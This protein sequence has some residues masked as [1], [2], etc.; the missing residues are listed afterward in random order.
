MS[1]SSFGSRSSNIS[2]KSQ[3]IIDEIQKQR[4]AEA[5]AA[6]AESQQLRNQIALLTTG[7]STSASETVPNLTAQQQQQKQQQHE[8]QL[9]RQLGSESEQLAQH[10]NSNRVNYCNCF[11]ID[12]I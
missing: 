3:A 9:Q 2:V 5:A 12:K 8:Q 10:S 7:S 6:A 11:V 4:A 1:V